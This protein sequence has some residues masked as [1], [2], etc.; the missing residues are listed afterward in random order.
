MK[1]GKKRGLSTIVTTLI[2]ILLTIA[3]ISIVWGVVHNIVTNNVNRAE[4]C[5][6][7]FDK[8]TLNNEYTCYNVTSGDFLFSVNMK[9][10]DVDAVIF[11][12]TS[13]GSSESYTLTNENQTIAGL[14]PY[15]PSLP[16]STTVR[17]PGENAGLTY[18]SSDFKSGKP[19]SIEIAPIIN[20]QQCGVSDSSYEI[21]IC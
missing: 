14:L 6:N 7:T 13:K 1:S 16:G 9:D 2:L 12:I 11:S 19:D 20:G 4:S 17:L 18:V 15:L 10:I 8:I 5:F 21:G 3:L